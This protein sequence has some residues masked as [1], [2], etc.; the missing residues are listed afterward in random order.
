MTGSYLQRA[1]RPIETCTG[2]VDD[3]NDGWIDCSD[4]TCVTSSLC[5]NGATPQIENC[6]DNADNDG[7]GYNNCADRDCHTHAVCTVSY[8]VHLTGY[9]VPTLE[10]R[11]FGYIP[12]PGS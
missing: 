10:T 1:P 11:T 3:D 4:N 5:N 2:G 9:S 12:P 6:T 7:D 8:D